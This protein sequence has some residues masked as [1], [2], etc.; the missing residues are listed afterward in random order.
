MWEARKAKLPCYPSIIHTW[1]QERVS[2]VSRRCLEVANE[3]ASS[4]VEARCRASAISALACLSLTWTEVT[5]KVH[6]MGKYEASG[7]LGRI[8]DF[9]WEG[10]RPY[11]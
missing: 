10:V 1:R 5:D 8:C 2:S 3:R 7:K 11:A 9:V 4:E 6:R